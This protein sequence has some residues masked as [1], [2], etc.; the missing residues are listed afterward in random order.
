M[1]LINLDIQ[2]CRTK[3]SQTKLFAHELKF[4][5]NEHIIELE[6]EK[7]IMFLYAHFIFM[8]KILK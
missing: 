5:Y 6:T 1:Q 3:K 4:F 2:G 8:H 7:C